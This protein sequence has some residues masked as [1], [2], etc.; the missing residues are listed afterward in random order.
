[1]IV[2]LYG[3][4]G[5]QLFQYAVA[6]A[7]SFRFNSPLVLDLTWFNEVLHQSGMTVRKYALAPFDLPVQLQSSTTAPNKFSQIQSTLRS[8]ISRRLGI[9]FGEKRYAESSFRF[10]KDVL[11]LQPPVWL[12]GY[13][14][15]HYYFDD[16]ANI[17]RKDL[18][19]TCT[20]SKNSAEILK[21]ISNTDSIC[22]HVRRGDYVTNKS[23]SL[24]HGLCTL[25]YYLKG[26]K[27]VTQGLKHPHG[28]VFSDDPEWVKAN[29]D[30]GID[31]TVVDVN[32]PDDAHQD[33]WLMSACKH[34]VIANSSLSW[35]GAWLGNDAEKRVIYPNRWFTDS[36]INTSDLF[37]EEWISL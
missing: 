16:V 4:L 20:L 25:E 14:Q 35:W 37:P 7:I 32:G 9:H 27:L 10:D 21:K 28:F 34:F 33:L 29:L 11:N 12:S 15:S 22:V 8:L 2:S 36:T 26:V 3:G 23:A 30:I 24:F 18:S 19:I 31:F 17:I 13:W 6:R 1:V 5:N